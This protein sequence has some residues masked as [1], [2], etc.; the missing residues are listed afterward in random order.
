MTRKLKLSLICLMA[1]V[2]LT[3]LAA[4]DEQGIS[5]T[6]W[7]WSIGTESPVMAEGGTGNCF[8]EAPARHYILW[9]GGST[10]TR[11][12]Y[13]DCS[14]GQPIGGWTESLMGLPAEE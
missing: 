13:A 5:S 7:G 6:F 10:T 12:R 8:T 4:P 1:F 11:Y 9:I 14:T 2:S 3:S